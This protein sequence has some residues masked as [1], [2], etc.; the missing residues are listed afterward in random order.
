MR[1]QKMGLDLDESLEKMGLTYHQNTRYMELIKMGSQVAKIK[2]YYPDEYNKFSNEA[3]KVIEA[4]LAAIKVIGRAAL[5]LG[6]LHGTR[7]EYD[8]KTLTFKEVGKARD[9]DTVLKELKDTI[10]S[11]K[12]ATKVVEKETEANKVAEAARNELLKEKLEAEEAKMKQ[13]IT[14]DKALQKHLTDRKKAIRKKSQED[15]KNLSKEQLLKLE[16]YEN[17]NV[18]TKTE[19]TRRSEAAKLRERN[20]A[21]RDMVSKLRMEAPLELRKKL[22]YAEFAELTDVCLIKE[23]KISIKEAWQHDLMS[24]Y[25]SKK[26]GEEP[27]EALSMM[28]SEIKKI[29]VKQ[30]DLTDAAILKNSA[31]LE[32]Y[33]KAL[34]SYNILMQRNPKFREANKKELDPILMIQKARLDYF[35]IRRTL[36]CNPTWQKTGAEGLGAAITEKDDIFGRQSKRLFSACQSMSEKLAKG[37]SNADEA[38]SFSLLL[39]D[40]IQQ[41][42]N[43]PKDYMKLD[44]ANPEAYKYTHD[45]DTIYLIGSQGA[46]AAKNQHN[47]I[48]NMGRDKL[49]TDLRK[50]VQQKFTTTTLSGPKF[51]C[52]KDFSN[53]WEIADSMSRML[54]MFCGP[55]TQD[56][57]SQE[58]LELFHNL[59]ISQSY[60]GLGMEDDAEQR[61]FCEQAFGDA[62]ARFF[63]L[64]Q[65]NMKKAAYSFGD[66]MVLAHPGDIL[67][68]GTPLLRE[69]IQC[70]G[71]YSNTA[72]SWDDRLMEKYGNNY[73]SDFDKETFQVLGS[74]TCRFSGVYTNMLSAITDAYGDGTD[75]EA[76][77]NQL[78]ETKENKPYMLKTI[79]KWADKK[80]NF[81]DKLKKYFFAHPE[82]LD[83]DR[84][85]KIKKKDGSDFFPSYASLPKIMALLNNIDSIKKYREFMKK[86]GHDYKKMNEKEVEN[87]MASLKKRGYQTILPTKGKDLEKMEEVIDDMKSMDPDFELELEG[88]ANLEKLYVNDF[89]GVSGTSMINMFVLMKE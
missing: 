27:D 50:M 53:T 64:M 35:R 19:K 33:S 73:N 29:S 6:E 70:L 39:D 52:A 71:I 80:L 49:L 1:I 72:G 24:K 31:K 59:A 44:L 17:S 15:E 45:R 62:A 32:N 3:K 18:T 9:A 47:V 43:V 34:Y 81:M 26:S 11:Y 28:L 79:M 16:T 69:F 41:E 20:F 48:K 42:Q 56:M 4:Q 68:Q 86:H 5:L 57:S 12:K 75:V 84:I 10:E 78:E 21:A 61:E 54:G 89:K 83:P 23:G 58:V 13:R 60:D 74:L 87:Y 55:L 30:E 2:K 22:N 46:D 38:E 14:K 7:A 82:L 8:E 67:K 40:L 77:D 66:T 65:C 51:S 88:N 63:T 85:Q 37:Y 76:I 36:L 25:A